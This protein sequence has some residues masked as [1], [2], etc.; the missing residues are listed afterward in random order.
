MLPIIV[1]S[2]L[3][4]CVVFWGLLVVS[5]TAPNH[6]YNFSDKECTFN[7][8]AITFCVITCVCSIIWG[9]KY[10]DRWNNQ[11]DIEAFIQSKTYVEFINIVEGTTEGSSELIDMTPMGPMVEK[12]YRDICWTNERINRMNQENAHWVWNWHTPDWDA[13]PLIVFE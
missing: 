10:V 11:R 1:F 5:R 7:G 4:L 8:L 9:V 2:C 6:K 12:L 13:P 3:F